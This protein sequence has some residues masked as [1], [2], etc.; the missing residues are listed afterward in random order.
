MHELWPLVEVSRVVF[1]AFDDEVIA[2]RNLKA[3]AKVLH[4]SADH[5]R[6]IKSA[7][8]DYPRG[9]TGGRSFAMGTSNHQRPV[10]ANE[11]F[12]ENFGQRAIK[13]P[14][15]ETLFDLRISTGN[16]V[17]N[18]DAIR[19]RFQMRS[20]VPLHQA[21]AESFKHRGHRRVDVFVRTRNAMSARLQH[22]RQ[23]SHRSSADSD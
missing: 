12:L 15:T 13:Q 4:D 14:A 23:R 17:T 20:V 10:A 9:Q 21:D 1:V 8:I 7:L 2:V 19:R 5:E 16:S 18:H 6:G 22:S 11:F 3:R